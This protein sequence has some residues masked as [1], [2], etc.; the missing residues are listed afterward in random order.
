MIALPVIQ[1]LIKLGSS[2]RYSVFK[3]PNNNLCELQNI[4]PNFNFL[5]SVCKRVMRNDNS[6]KLL[7]T[8]GA[9]YALTVVAKELQH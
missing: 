1:K 6:D 5:W 9:D 2:P 7:N 4:G 8:A 3:L